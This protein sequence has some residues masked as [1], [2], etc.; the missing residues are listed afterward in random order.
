[1]KPS[2][3]APC[4]PDG[5]DPNLIFETLNRYTASLDPDRAISLAPRGEP[6]PQSTRARAAN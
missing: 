1:M 3:I 6:P 4:R 5:Y 2:S